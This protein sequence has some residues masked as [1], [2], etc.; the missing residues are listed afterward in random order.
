MPSSA[1]AWCMLITSPSGSG[2]SPLWQG[3]MPWRLRMVAT[4]ASIPGQVI[5]LRLPRGW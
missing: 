3:G 5:E 1:A 4:L 2:A